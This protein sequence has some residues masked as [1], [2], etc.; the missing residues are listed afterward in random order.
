MAIVMNVNDRVEIVMILLSLLINCFLF[1]HVMATIGGVH[2]KAVIQKRLFEEEAI[3][4]SGCSKC[5]ML[6]SDLY[7]VNLPLLR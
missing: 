3:R 1:I 6:C 2:S 7:L 5:S 4:R